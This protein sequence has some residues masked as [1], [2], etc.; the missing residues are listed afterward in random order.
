[1]AQEPLDK[2]YRFDQSPSAQAER[3]RKEARGTPAGVKRDQLLRRAR[4]VESKVRVQGW[5]S[6]ATPKLRPEPDR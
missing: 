6:R 3:L 5:L 2:I 1:M 4:Q